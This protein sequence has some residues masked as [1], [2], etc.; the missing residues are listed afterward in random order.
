MD[1]VERQKK[2]DLLRKLERLHK[3]G[4]IFEACYIHTD[5]NV[6]QS[7]YDRLIGQQKIETREK[8]IKQLKSVEHIELFNSLDIQLPGNLDDLTDEELEE[9]ATKCGKIAMMRL[10]D[11]AF[12]T[13]KKTA[14]GEPL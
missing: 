3:K 6:L 11:D 7:V 5:L 4:Y 12:A 1:T 9:G 8:L 13:M 2:I 10:L 14:N